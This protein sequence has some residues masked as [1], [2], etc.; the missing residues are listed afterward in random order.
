MKIIDKV[1]K[2]HHHILFFDFEATQFSQEIIAYGAVL[3]SLDKN[4]NIK[5]RKEPI[6]R[7]ILPKNQIGHI[8]TG[9]TGITEEM[10]RKNGILFNDAMLD[11]KKYCGIA[12]K[13][14]VFMA[15]GPSDLRMLNRSIQYNLKYPKEITQQ[16]QK[17]FFDFQKLISTFIKDEHSNPMSLVHYLEFY[18]IKEAGQ[19]HD[20]MIDAV[21]TAN[22]YQAFVSNKE[23]LF[24]SYKNYLL[25]SANYPT[26]VTQALRLLEKNNNISMEE[27]EALIK[28]EIK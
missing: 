16:I 6:R 5:K 17:N 7:Y 15:F 18:G 24:T 25:K 9:L 13:K 22:L 11:L 1:L 2:G 8:V 21:N 26:P 23:I 3:V 27:F 28:D 10:I 4:G 14:C 20:P 12:F 19:A